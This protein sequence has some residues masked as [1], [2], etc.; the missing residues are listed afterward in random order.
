MELRTPVCSVRSYR[1]EDA[2]SLARNGDNRKVWLNLRD[3]FPH[4]FGVADGAR[5]IADVLARPQ[6]TSFAIAV[7]EEAVG[8][9][10]LR[11]GTDIERVTAELG[12]WIGEPYWGRGLASAAVEAVT[13]YGFEA[14]GLRRIF[15]IPFVENVASCRVLEKAGYVREG[16]MRAS[17]IKDGEIRDQYLYSRISG[18]AGGAARSA[19]GARV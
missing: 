8:G 9:I 11:L 17:A 13:P 2:V 5:Y 1:P 14:F 15:A 4:P 16:L 10:S 12:Y 19:R 3:R 18:D 6:E 7:G